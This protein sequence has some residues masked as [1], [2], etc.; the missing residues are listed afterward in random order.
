VK[1]STGE[2]SCVPAVSTVYV[3][4]NEAIH[5]EL[6]WNTPN[7]P[8]QTNTGNN[9]GADLD[10]HFTHPLAVGGYD[11][12]GDGTMDGW[13]DIPYD[14]FW[15]NEE[16]N[17]NSFDP[18]IDDNPSLDRDDTDGAGPEN[19]NLNIPENGVKYKVGVH[20][21]DDHG[22]GPSLATVRTYIYG[23]PVFE[24]SGIE[25]LHRDMWTVTEVE[26][27]PVN[28]RPPQM[29]RVCSGTTR[30]CTNDSECGAGTCGARIAP[31]Y[32]HP[33]YFQP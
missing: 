13:F 8:D 10:M 6:L 27:P 26:W 15:D 5:I 21:W 17:W 14:C 28:G 9:A 19:V 22:F 23:V 7:D 29:V 24:V 12:D 3:N 1:D 30:A 11:G 33:D 2:N 31:N 18:A 4:P 20:Y 16:P 32:N 25:L